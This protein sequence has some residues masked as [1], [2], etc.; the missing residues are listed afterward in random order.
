MKDVSVNPYGFNRQKLLEEITRTLSAD[1]R[2]TAAWLTGSFGRGEE[3]LVSDL[4]LSVVV[5]KPFDIGLCERE[6]QVSGGT[7]AERLELFSH[8]GLP[9]VIHENN[10][11]A[12]AGGTFTF[13]LYTGSALMVDWT[14]VPE[15]A[16]RRPEASLLLFDKIGVPRLH[17]PAPENLEQRLEKITELTAF[18]W[19]MTAVTIK[20]IHRGDGVF[21]QTWLENLTAIEREVERQIDGRPIIYHHGS[22][23]KP[24]PM[25]AE[26]I[27]AIRNLAARMEQLGVRA[28]TPG[29]KIPAAPKDEIEVL[30]SLLPGTG[31]VK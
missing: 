13:V 11:N 24:L 17:S 28:K 29:A 18:F 12:P 31:P 15:S 4:D 25:P 26:Q 23:T 3:D 16:A 19:M 14:L 21:V 1:E 6:Q 27:Q 20:Y 2:F 8:F 5:Q 30:L 7:T 10:H 9:A 22:W